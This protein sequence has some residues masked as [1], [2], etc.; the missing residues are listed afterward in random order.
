MSHCVVD[1]K[2]LNPRVMK[3]IQTL[4]LFDKNRQLFFNKIL[5]FIYVYICMGMF[6]FMQVPK[7]ARRWRQIP[8]TGVAGSCEWTNMD[9]GNDLLEPLQEQYML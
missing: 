3:G 6:I 8:G 5:Y 1:L 9:A 7:E 2:M 4:K